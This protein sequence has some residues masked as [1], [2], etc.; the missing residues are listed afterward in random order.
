MAEPARDSRDIDGMCRASRTCW[1]NVPGIPAHL[2]DVPGIPDTLGKRVRHPSH[3][4]QM[5]RESP[6]HLMDALG[7]PGTFDGCAGNPRHV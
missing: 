6:A 5:C 2:M 3:I 7:T 4:H 1:E